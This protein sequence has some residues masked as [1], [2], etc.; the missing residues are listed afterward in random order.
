MSL[1]PA[2]PEVAV[3]AK[4]NEISTHNEIIFKADEAAVAAAAEHTLTLSDVLR[5]HRRIVY[6][7]LFFSMSAIGW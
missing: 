5:H 4:T 2:P 3:E 6:W 1:N 7:C